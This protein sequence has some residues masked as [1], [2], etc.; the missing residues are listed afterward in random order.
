ML[1]G[2]EVAMAKLRGAFSLIGSLKKAKRLGAKLDETTNLTARDTFPPDDVR[3]ESTDAQTLLLRIVGGTTSDADIFAVLHV[4]ASRD[5]INA[6]VLNLHTHV[7]AGATVRDL[8]NES[9]NAMGVAIVE[10][11]MGVRVDYV[12]ELSWEG[13]IGLIDEIG[14]L[15]TYS[16]RTFTSVGKTFTEGTNHLDGAATYTFCAADPVDDAEQ[17]RTRNQ[18]AVLRALLNTIDVRKL[19][20]DAPSLTRIL[21]HMTRGMKKTPNFTSSAITHVATQLRGLSR[22]DVT[23][24]MVPS[25]SSRTADGQVTADFDTQELTTLRSALINGSS[26]EVSRLA[27]EGF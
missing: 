27:A 20:K 2:T 6:F 22:K 9:G 25:V 18:R 1:K 7:E 24:I 12:V 19:A 14:P 10:E 8:F 3:L 11:L 13:F 15:P 23:A 26:A 5:A 4:P 16:R 21:D 17:T